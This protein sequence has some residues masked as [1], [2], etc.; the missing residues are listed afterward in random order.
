MY[1]LKLEIRWIPEAL[2][3]TLRA[4][5]MKRD[6]AQKAWAAYL[7]AETH[8]VRKKLPTSPLKSAELRLVRHSHRM[9]DFDGLVGSMKPVVDGLKAAGVILDDRWS[10]TGAWQVDQRFRPKAEGPL[11]EIHVLERPETQLT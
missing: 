9:L 6:R 2:N 4:H 8:A 10:V 7:C 5:R 11:L 1:E 3:V